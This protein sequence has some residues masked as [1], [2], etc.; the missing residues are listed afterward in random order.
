MCISGVHLQ[1][2]YVLE[3]T[4]ECNMRVFTEKKNVLKI[5]Q[6]GQWKLLFIISYNFDLN[7]SV[8]LFPPVK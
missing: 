4:T 2:K 1:L 5:S 6:I 7:L 8:P 3:V